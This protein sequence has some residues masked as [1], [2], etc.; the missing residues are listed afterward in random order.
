MKVLLG[1][2]T[3]SS[4]FSVLC[5]WSEAR[6]HIPPL[7]SVAE[8]VAKAMGSER[9][10]IEIGSQEFTREI[11][12][13]LSRSHAI[14]T[15]EDFVLEV[16]VA[17]IP[18]LMEKE[19]VKSLWVSGPDCIVVPTPFD[20]EVERCRIMSERAYSSLATRYYIE[21]TISDHWQEYKCRIFSSL[22]AQ[23][24]RDGLLPP[25]ARLVYQN[26]CGGK[27][28]RD[29]LRQHGQSMEWMGK[30]GNF[31]FGRSP[32]FPCMVGIQTFFGQDSRYELVM[33]SRF[34]HAER[35]WQDISSGE[36]PLSAVLLEEYGEIKDL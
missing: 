21:V 30:Q 3:N 24:I 9:F 2:V 13:L 4:T 8:S 28:W 19:Q 26:V 32:R 10:Y 20:G 6:E 34:L 5:W 16:E 33:L 31:F 25:F 36:L 7:L 1:A 11:M 23:G 14:Y 12:G 29:L 35:V 22:F 27:S 18:R 17:D 15:G